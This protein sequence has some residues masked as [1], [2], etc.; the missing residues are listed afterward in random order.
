M[1]AELEVKQYS[2]L[3]ELKHLSHYD[4]TLVRNKLILGLRQSKTSVIIVRPLQTQHYGSMQHQT[5]ARPVA[6]LLLPIMG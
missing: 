6:K 2:Q 1:W 3:A 4:L 5:E